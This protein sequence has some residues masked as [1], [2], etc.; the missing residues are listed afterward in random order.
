[1]F[2][3]LKFRDVITDLFI[4]FLRCK[5]DLCSECF[6]GEW[7][8][9]L[10]SNGEHPLVPVDPRIQ[11]R[12]YESWSCDICNRVGTHG[13]TNWLLFHCKQ[14]QEDICFSCYQGQT[15]H[16][17]PHGLV[18]RERTQSRRDTTTTY[19]SACSRQLLGKSFYSCRHP[20]CSFYLCTNCFQMSPRPHPLHP[21]HPL[22]MSNSEQV[23]P[24]SGGVWHCDNC[25]KMHPL[26]K[27]TPLTSAN[28]MY[29]CDTCQF[30]L[31]H[32]CYKN[33]SSNSDIAPP[34]PWTPAPPSAPLL[35]QHHNYFSSKEQYKRPLVSRPS[36]NFIPS[37]SS[38]LPA[39]AICRI[40]GLAAARLT[41]THGGKPH[42][43]P[44]YCQECAKHVLDSRE[45]CFKCS[46]V[47]DGM[48]M[49]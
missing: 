9:V 36:V 38:S 40:C 11:Y 13:S 32:M 7:F 30:D 27:A 29:H 3:C 21:A 35:S 19:C 17:H 10:H 41:P 28:H 16:L 44:L 5:I 15:H 20:S 45:T 43:E 26:Q 25:T 12:C 24:E 34:I 37:P 42:S 47:P 49:V 31:C 22:Y 2:I 18:L 23:Y 8:H 48:V 14:C 1:M 33:G 39:P 6:Q 46:L 4:I